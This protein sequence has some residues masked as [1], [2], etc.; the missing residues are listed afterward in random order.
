MLMKRRTFIKSSALTAFSVAAVGAVHWDGNAFTGDTTTTTD[1]LGPY[2]R[3]GAPMRNN[4]IPPDAKGDILHLNGTIFQS[5]SRTP[6]SD[7][8]VEAWQCNPQQ[9]YDN[10]S[11]DF[12]FRGH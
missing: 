7:V 10:A 3:P 1:I 12:L 11:D 9:H 4:L 2:Y 5:D 8:L 6:L